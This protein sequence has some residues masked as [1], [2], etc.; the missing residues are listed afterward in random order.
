MTVKNCE[1]TPDDLNNIEP[2]AVYAPIHRLALTLTAKI[3]PRYTRTVVADTGQILAI[4]GVV[5]NATRPNAWEAWAFVAEDIHP[6]HRLGLVRAI[7]AL[8]KEHNC[9]IFADT[10]RTDARAI[11]FAKACGFERVSNGGWIANIS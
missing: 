10:H 11:R 1:F 5:R 8:L 6:R 3:D 2:R 4:A 9:A 7:R